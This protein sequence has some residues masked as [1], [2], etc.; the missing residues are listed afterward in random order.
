MTPSFAASMASCIPCTWLLLHLT[1]IGKFQISLLFTHLR[2]WRE[3]VLQGHPE[4]VHKV[5]RLGQRVPPR[6][7]VVDEEAAEVAVQGWLQM[8][9]RGF[10]ISGRGDDFTQPALAEHCVTWMM[11]DN[12]VPHLF[13]GASSAIL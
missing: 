5:V 9:V 10:V 6:H 2:Q 7:V 4:D 13:P 8:W 12:S 11:G 1:L 3:L